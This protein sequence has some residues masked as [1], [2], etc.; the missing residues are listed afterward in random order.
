M[1]LP[2]WQAETMRFSRI[3]G[4]VP[5]IRP[6]LLDQQ[7]VIQLLSSSQNNGG[8][9][10]NNVKSSAKRTRGSSRALERSFM[11]MRN[12][13][14]P[15]TLPWWTLTSTGRGKGR[16]GFHWHIKFTAWVEEGR[17]PRMKTALNS[18]GR[19]FGLHCNSI[20]KLLLKKIVNSWH[21]F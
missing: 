5:F 8:N 4:H 7:R 17:N 11:Y 20:G 6:S 10:W 14:E 2:E 3:E 15:N 16:T 13:T 1:I 9:V 21:F 19:E 18:T 12:K